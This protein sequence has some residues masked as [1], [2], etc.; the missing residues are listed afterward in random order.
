MRKRSTTIAASRLGAVERLIYSPSNYWVALVGDQIAAVGFLALGSA[1]GDLSVL[2]AGLAVSAGFLAWGGVEYSVH[3]WVLHGPPSLARR[4]HA[5]HHAN[6]A[7]LIGAP[8]FMAVA[9]AAVVWAVLSLAL[10]GGLPALLVGGLYLG[11]NR[12]A[13]LHHFQHRQPLFTWIPGLVRLEAAH[14]LHHVQHVV[15]FGVST[16]L[17]DQLLGSSAP[18]SRDR[19]TSSLVRTIVKPVAESR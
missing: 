14:R 18:P 6:G 12:Y 13:L 11:Y 5:R 10:T 9:A 8:A 2:S 1:A 19:R 16:L 17:W 3:R 7:A 15:N 4:A